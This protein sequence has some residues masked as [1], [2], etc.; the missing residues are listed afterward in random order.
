[1]VPALE[2]KPIYKKINSVNSRWYAIQF[3]NN[4]C[5]LADLTGGKLNGRK[6]KEIKVLLSIFLNHRF[7]FGKKLSLRNTEM[8]FSYSHSYVCQHLS[9]GLSKWRKI[10]WWIIGGKSNTTINLWKTEFSF[11]KKLNIPKGEISIFRQLLRNSVITLN[12]LPIG[13]ERF[14]ASVLVAFCIKDVVCLRH[15]KFH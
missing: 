9:V 11:W 2:E 10:E 3:Y 13:A 6:L 8:K 12:F 7:C 1:M 4:I 5:A 15:E 14:Y